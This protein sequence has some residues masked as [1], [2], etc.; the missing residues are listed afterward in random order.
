MTSQVKNMLIGCFV[1]AAC[2][3]IIG[4]I[5]FIEPSVGDGKQKLIARFSNIN[6]ISVGTRVLFAGK[7]IGEVDSIETIPHARQQRVDHSGNVYIYQ[8]LLKID[9]SVHVY[10]TDEISVQTSG[11]LGEKSIAITPKIPPKG[12]K[13]KLITMK[14]PVYAISTD[15]LEAMFAD[16]SDLSEKADKAL[17]DI[18]KWFNQNSQNLSFAVAAFGEALDQIS[19]AVKDVNEQQIIPEIKLSA[20]QLSL[21]LSE[22]QEGMK[23][24][25][26]Q[27]FFPH[28][29][30]TMS[31]MSSITQS[32]NVTAKDLANGTGT[33]GKLI[34]NDD[35]YLR[36]MGITSKI[37][38]LLNDVNSYGLLF[39]YNKQ[40]Q[41]TRERQ[42]NMLNSLSTP[43]SFR[44]YFEGQLSTINNAMNRL[45]MLIEK[46]ENS[47]NK[48]TIFS[49]EIFHQDFA[50]LLKRVDELASHLKLYNEQLSNL[51]KQE[52]K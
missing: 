8:L 33:I 31:N 34:N 13:P 23:A 11:L 38:T 44:D 28:L 7:P 18:M 21:I 27:D 2:A 19:I 14:T 40:W 9:S 6:G 48:T 5:L 46:A 29:A 30:T 51:S 1:I 4:M 50:T 41:R 24:L 10:N 37:D 45:S 22:V 39:N 42:I 3:L 17:E 49:N 12:V 43:Q 20:Q 15:P 35:M 16:I 25:K 47:N 32:F 52:C 26:K 36:V